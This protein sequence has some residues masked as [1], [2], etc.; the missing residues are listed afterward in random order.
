M[1]TSLVSWWFCLRLEHFA[2]IERQFS[3]TAGETPALRGEGKNETKM[4][5]NVFDG[6]LTG[7]VIRD[8]RFS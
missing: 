2:W 3:P 7:G 1:F 6:N 4:K 8:C 5:M